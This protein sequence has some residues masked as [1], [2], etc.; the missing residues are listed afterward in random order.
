MG[1]LLDYD[2]GFSDAGAV[3]DALVSHAPGLGGGVSSGLISLSFKMSTGT[4]SLPPAI[5]LCLVV[6]QDDGYGGR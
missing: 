2:Q 3:M 1:L 6:S 4:N 5:A